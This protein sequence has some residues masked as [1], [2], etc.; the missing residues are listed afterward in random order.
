MSVEF[1]PGD[2]DYAS[3][4]VKIKARQM[5]RRTG[6]NKSHREDL[7]RELLLDLLQRLPHFDPERASRKT[8]IDRVVNHMVAKIIRA[9][10]R[11][12]RDFRLNECSLNEMVVDGDGVTV[13]RAETIDQDEPLIR[14]GT[15]R[16]SEMDRSDLA[17][18][19]EAVIEKFPPEWREVLERLKSQSIRQIAAEMGMPKST[20]WNTIETIRLRMAE[21]GLEDYLR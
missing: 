3:K 7:E 16:A 8:Y 17:M 12:K 21:E 9:R 10:L 1:E 15:T 13:E 4:V 5:I 11:E 2:L 19:L 18:D 20:L 14:L 6:F